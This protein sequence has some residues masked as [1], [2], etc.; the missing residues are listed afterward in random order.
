MAG[1]GKRFLVDGYNLPKP[2]IT[3]NEKPMIQLVVENLNLNG[4][5]I[6]IINKIQN[7]R[8]TLKKVLYSLN[9]KVS[10]IEIDYLTEGPAQTAL[11]AEKYIDE[12]PLIIAN[13]DQVVHDFDFNKLVEFVEKQNA[14]GVLGAFISTSDKNSYMELNGD[15]EVLNIKEKIVISNIATN[16]LHFWKSGKDFVSSC[17]EMIRAN[18]RYNNE[19]YIA[20]S[21]NYLIKNSKK[22]LPYFYNLHW[23][24][25]TPEDLIK[26]KNLYGYI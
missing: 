16:G 18:E 5:Y 23:P 22:I 24:I 1:E 21:Y 6:F 26:Y 15:G 12:S 25:G 11:L 8:E 14:D 20:P 19:F 9:K 10:I 7:N 3:I 4:N 2:L 13:C 17:K